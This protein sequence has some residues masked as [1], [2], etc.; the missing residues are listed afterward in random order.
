MGINF[1]SVYPGDPVREK[2]WI[3]LAIAAGSAIAGGMMQN[4]ANKDMQNSANSTNEKLAAENRA[5]QENMSNTAHQRAVLDLK[6]AGLNPILSATQGGASTP[7]GGAAT[8]GA[9]RMEDVIGKGVSS[10]KDAYALDLQTKSTAADIA[11]KDA[12]TASAAAQAAQSISSAKKIDAETT[13]V[14]QSN[15]FKQ[16][17]APAA[18]SRYELENQKNQ[19]DKKAATYDAIMNR[20]EQATGMIGNLLPAVKFKFQKGDEKMRTEHKQMKDFLRKSR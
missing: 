8:A 2:N 11:L 9:A 20:A 6:A 17:E 18:K 3:P 16:Y 7:S 19:L 5:W 1:F 10:A 12:S 15:V 13:G 14:H 4:S